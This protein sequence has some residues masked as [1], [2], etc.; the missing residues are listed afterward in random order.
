MAYKY[1]AFIS[2]RH[3]DIKEAKRLQGLIER[4]SLPVTLQRQRPDAPKR[5]KVFRDTDELTSGELNEELRKKL[6][7]S[8][9][10][11]VICSPDSA[12]SKYVGKEIAYFRSKGRDKEIIPFIIKG[13]PHSKDNECFHPQLTLG[14]LELLGIDVQAE[15]PSLGWSRFRKAFIRLVAKTLDLSFDDLW[16]RRK[17]YIIRL[18]CLQVAMLAVI[19]ALIGYALM[20]RPFDANVKLQTYITTLPLSADETD[21]LYLYLSDSDVRAMPI[22]DV[23]DA[24]VFPNIPGKYKGQK[25]RIRSKAFGFNDLDT[26]VSI[27]NDMSL[28]IMR[29]AETFGRIRYRIAD[30][31]SDRPL[32]N[33]VFDFGSVKTTTDSHGMLVVLIPLNQ[34]RKSYPMRISHNGKPMRLTYSENGDTIFPTQSEEISTIY[35]E[36][37]A[38]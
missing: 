38:K 30:N 19:A 27:D 5:F 16:N 35:I 12:Q 20:S 24:I 15:T 28:P 14:G 18:R 31:E 13:V 36:P 21:S 29:N 25:L 22:K 17:R 11:V 10:L 26:L 6:N 2:Y 9:W 23:E 34:Q 33:V 37:S 32:P 4:Y 3:T 8:K 1:F 7:Q